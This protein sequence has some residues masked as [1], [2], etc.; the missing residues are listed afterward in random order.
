[1]QAI[2][3]TIKITYSCQFC[4]KEFVKELTLES[5]ICELKRRHLEIDDRGV[6]IGFRAFLRFF[7]VAAK[8]SRTKNYS[9]FVSSPYYRAFV[10]FGKYII[11][12]KAIAPEAFVDWLLKNNKK[13]DFWCKDSLYSE[14]LNQHLK[15]EPVA[16]ALAR[17]IEYGISWG[18]TQGMQTHDVMRYGSPNRVVFAITTGRISAWAVYNS[19]SGQEF[20]NKLSG[21]HVSMVWPFIDTDFWQKKF[22]DNPNDQVYARTML[23]MAGW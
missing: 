10:K 14:F 6:Q 15:V 17:A 2:N 1:M 22:Q 20:L 11:G 19:D 12:V 23:N 5:H 18:E 7:E 8:G 21:E 13:I 16:D 3:N 9:D 4:K